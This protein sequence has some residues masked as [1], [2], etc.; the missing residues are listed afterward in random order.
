LTTTAIESAQRRQ[1][2]WDC[3]QVIYRF[4]GCLD[5]HLYDELAS[6]FTPT[7][8]WVRLGK[9]LVGPEG[10]LEG[11]G[12]RSDWLTVHL[13]T[14]VRITVEDLDHASSSQYVTLYRHEGWNR[15]V[16]GPAPVVLPLGILR[17]R[18]RLVR[19]EDEWRFQRKESSA[20]MV[21]RGRV[22]HYE[23]KRDAASR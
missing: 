12:E 11:I 19:E 21:D 22:T 13:I 4:Y 20:V 6:L 7:G 8:A 15:E 10:I 1:I 9:E 16:Q 3:T 2:E 5:D 18:D 23:E 14:N 17:H